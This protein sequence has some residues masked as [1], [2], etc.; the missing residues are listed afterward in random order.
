MLLFQVRCNPLSGKNNNYNAK[1]IKK[2]AS[3]WFFYAV[4]EGVEP[5]R[6]D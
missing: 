1:D 6:R 2:P 4:G 3:C 5:S